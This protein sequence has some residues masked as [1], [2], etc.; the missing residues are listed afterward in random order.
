MVQIINEENNN[1]D[2][3]VKRLYDLIDQLNAVEK[4]IILIVYRQTFTKRN[5]KDSR[6]KRGSSE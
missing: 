1:E 2:E 3:D 4:S 5:S 6:L